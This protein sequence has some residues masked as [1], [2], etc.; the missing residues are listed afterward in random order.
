MDAQDVIKIG[1]KA[2]SET[3][4]FINSYL[5][6]RAKGWP[7]LRLCTSAYSGSRQQEVRNRGVY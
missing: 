5:N 2:K 7:K 6:D 1:R 3:E 4:A